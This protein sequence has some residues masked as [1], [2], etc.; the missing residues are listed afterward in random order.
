MVT[1]R[2]QGKG[3]G[4]QEAGGQGQENSRKAKAGGT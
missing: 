3:G 2:T 1:S 4:S